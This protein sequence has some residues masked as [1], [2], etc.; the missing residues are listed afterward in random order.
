V[1]ESKQSLLAALALKRQSTHRPGYKNLHELAGG[2][3]ECQFV[4][5]YSKTAGNVD[6]DLFVFLQDLSSEEQFSGA[7]DQDT[8]NLGYTPSVKTNTNLIR[9]LSVHFN[10]SLA[11]IYASNVFPLIKSGGMSARI[12]LD[13]LSWA[14]AEFALPQIE[15]VRPRLTIVLGVAAFDAILDAAGHPYSQSLG[16]AIEEPFEYK[17][18]KIWCQAHTGRGAGNRGSA[19]QIARDW[20]TMAN[21]YYNQASS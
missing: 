7:Q 4:S 12:P 15:I 17:G 18:S 19:A 6:S 9:L 13:D 16:A 1:N 3:Y 21:W 11:D 8:I 2:A 5:P 14:A 10:R 20:R